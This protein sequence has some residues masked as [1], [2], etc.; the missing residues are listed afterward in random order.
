MADRLRVSRLLEIVLARA[1]SIENRLGYEPR[2]RK[3]VRQQ[4]RSRHGCVRKALLKDP[5]DLRVQ[6]MPL[7]PQQ[8]LVRRALN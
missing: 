8:A 2:F 1:L 4:L 3:V 6:L 5:P 7:A